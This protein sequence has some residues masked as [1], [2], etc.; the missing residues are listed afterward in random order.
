MEPGSCTDKYLVAALRGLGFNY[1]F[2]T[3]VGADLTI[4]EEGYEVWNTLFFTFYLSIML[5]KL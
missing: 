1:V 2:S 3:D 5:P 4:M